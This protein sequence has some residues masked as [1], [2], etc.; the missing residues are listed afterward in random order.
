MIERGHAKIPTAHLEAGDH[1]ANPEAGR[2][3]M[4]A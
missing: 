1:G 4:Y 2:Y 3:E